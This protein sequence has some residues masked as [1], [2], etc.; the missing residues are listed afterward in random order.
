MQVFPQSLFRSM[1]EGFVD[2]DGEDEDEGEDGAVQ[3]TET[4]VL[5]R[6]FVKAACSRKV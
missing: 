1:E 6:H 5:E 4:R 2:L 3:S